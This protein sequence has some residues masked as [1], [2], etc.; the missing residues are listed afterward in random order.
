MTTF[1]RRSSSSSSASSSSTYSGSVS[2][3]LPSS[4]FKSKISL[5]CYSGTPS[6]ATSP[7]ES[8]TSLEKFSSDSSSTT[9]TSSVV[10]TTIKLPVHYVPHHLPT[11]LQCGRSEKNRDSIEQ[12]LNAGMVEMRMLAWDESRRLQKEIELLENDSQIEQKLRAMGF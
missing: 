5:R 10:K 3:P 1:H 12:N 8:T 2:S 7:A 4:S 11:R 6:G 9:S